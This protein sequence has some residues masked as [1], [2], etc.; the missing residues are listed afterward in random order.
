[1]AGIGGK[2]ETQKREQSGLGAG[3]K[4]QGCSAPRQARNN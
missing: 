4:D 1:M 2:S 3:M